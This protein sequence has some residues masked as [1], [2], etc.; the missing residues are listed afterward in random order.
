MHGHVLQDFVTIRG[1]STVTTVT[2]T[3][4]AW[5]DVTPYQ[6]LFA[7]I[8]VREVTLGTWTGIQIN[9]QTAPIKD[10]FLF[11]N[12]QATPL[13][14]TGALSTPSIIQVIYSAG[15]GT[16][17]VA[18]GSLLRWQLAPTGGTASTWDI[19]FRIAVC[20][21]MVASHSGGGRGGMQ[22]MPAG[23]MAGTGMRFGG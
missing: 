8:D 6:D 16:N 17:K 13:S 3:E 2:Q 12:L 20:C 7:W 9:L 5:L 21:N 23:G 22:G 14:V 10:E 1:A 15:S 19:T 11:V 18:L 4:S